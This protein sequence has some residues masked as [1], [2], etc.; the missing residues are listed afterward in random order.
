MC[1]RFK[2]VEER[3]PLIEAMKVFLP[4]MLNSFKRSV[5]DNSAVSALL[6]KQLL[7]ILYALVQVEICYD[8]TYNFLSFYKVAN[9]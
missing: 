5:E 8:L 7:K 1:I 4:A 3:G 6:Q 9:Q 2:K